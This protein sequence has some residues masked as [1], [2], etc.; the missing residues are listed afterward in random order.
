MTMQDMYSL[1]A[2][3]NTLQSIRFHLTLISVGYIY[4]MNRKNG[5]RIWQKLS[6]TLNIFYYSKIVKL[7]PYSTKKT[8]FRVNSILS[9]GYPLISSLIKIGKIHFLE[10]VSLTFGPKHNL[11]TGFLI[12][13]FQ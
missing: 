6:D 9:V 10:F 12:L 7:S 13:F 5:T 4:N 8:Q 11:Q 1:F 3:Y 2:A